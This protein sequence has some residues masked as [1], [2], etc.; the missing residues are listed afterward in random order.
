[1]RAALRRPLTPGMARP[2]R[3]FGPICLT[4]RTNRSNSIEPTIWAVIG[5]TH[6]RRRQPHRTSRQDVVC[7]TITTWPDEGTATG[8]VNGLAQTWWE[9]TGSGPT[10]PADGL[11][12][13]GD[14]LV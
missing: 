14:R 7:P 6:R 1:M 2:T 9:R 8:H 11:G 12:P 13:H 4:D 5:A 3:L 10:D